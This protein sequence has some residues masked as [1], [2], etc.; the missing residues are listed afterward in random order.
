MSKNSIDQKILCKSEFYEILN[1]I[2][3]GRSS[4]IISFVNPFSYFTLQKNF[5]AIKNID[6]LFSDGSLLCLFHRVFIG[7]K[8]IRASFDYSSLASTVFDFAAEKKIKIAI[9][10]GENGDANLAVQT[11]QYMHPQLKVVYVRHGYFISEFEKKEVARE[12]SESGA[13]I[14][15][16]GMG[17]PYQE[18]FSGIIKEESPLGCLVF[19]CGGFLTQT[20]IRPDYYYKWVKI[21][22][23]RWLQRMIMH[24]YVRDRVFKYY[25]KFV[26][27]YIKQHL[28]K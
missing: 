25:P 24:K 5:K 23:L 1:S 9:V 17:T 14:I 26:F 16:V 28:F 27:Y 2:S 18:E 20:S 21:L 10:G 19:T 12:I 8:I 15:I 4:K 3:P 22:G 6:F 7:E 11:F 13:N